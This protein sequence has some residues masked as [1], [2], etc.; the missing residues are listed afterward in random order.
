MAPQANV[1]GVLISGKFGHRDRYA[2]RENRVM[3]RQRSA[4]LLEAKGA[5]D[6]STTRTL[7]EAGTEPPHSLRR[8]QPR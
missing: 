3:R 1:T 6:G 7:G 2:R 8:N 4:M 5:R